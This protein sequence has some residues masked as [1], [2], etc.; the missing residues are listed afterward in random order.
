MPFGTF[1]VSGAFRMISGGVK[2][3]IKCD[4]AKDVESLLGLTLLEQ[5]V[6]MIVVEVKKYNACNEEETLLSEPGNL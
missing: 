4:D 5:E 6:E 2:K 3:V 1:I